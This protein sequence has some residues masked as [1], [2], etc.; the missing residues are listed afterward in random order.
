MALADVCRTDATK[1]N[2]FLN[3]KQSF[4][5]RHQPKNEDFNEL[6]DDQFVV[7]TGKQVR[8]LVFNFIWCS[9]RGVENTRLE[10]NAK[11]SPSEDR[12]S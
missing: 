2:Y 8:S 3:F 7:P 11:D 5:T 4:G 6:V 12:H 1:G 10:A 9:R